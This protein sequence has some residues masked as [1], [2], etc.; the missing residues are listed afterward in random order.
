MWPVSA[1]LAYGAYTMRVDVTDTAGNV[2]SATAIYEA[3][4]RDGAS[5]P[6]AKAVLAHNNG[7]DTGLQ[8]GEYNVRMNLWWGE[9]GSIFHLYENGVR[10]ATVPLTYN[11]LN[12]QS[13]AIPISARANGE[14]RYTGELVNSKGTT[15]TA[16]VT[17]T[18]TQ[19]SPGTPV[20]NHDNRDDDGTF[21][22]T[23]NMWW[24]TNATQYTF[25]ENGVALATGQLEAKTPSAQVAVLPLSGRSVGSYNY[26]VE[27]VNAAG[28]TSSTTINVQVK[29]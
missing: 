4:L 9:N 20:L 21:N 10:V 19:A 7:W 12:A 2:G 14:Y 15:E 26:R 28:A 16:P 27:F 8:D 13:A 6:P 17:V 5:A 23:A 22:V 24:G 11:G 18:V 1:D 29:K 3:P 25:Y